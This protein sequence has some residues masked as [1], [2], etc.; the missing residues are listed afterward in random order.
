MDAN[1]VKTTPLYSAHLAL[2][3]KMISFA[4]YLLP[5]QYVGILEEHQA[6][7]ERAGVF[8]VSHMGEFIVR[9]PAAESYLQRLLT[10]DIGRLSVGRAQYSLMCNENGGVV[11]D[12][13]VYRKFTREYMLV[14]NANNIAKD[15]G[16]LQEHLQEEAEV[17]DI[18][19]DTALLAL[20]GPR[21][22]DILQ[23]LTNTDLSTLKYYHF[24][25]GQVGGLDCLISRTGYT[26]ED[27]F[28]L[29][30]AP[31]L[32]GEM[33]SRLLAAGK[34]YGLQPAGL[35]ARDTLR[36]E[37]SLPLYGNELTA[38]TTPL[39]AGLERF[40]DFGKP[41]FIGRE[42]LWRQKT[43][44]PKRRLQGLLML[45]QGVPRPGYPVLINNARAGEVTSGSY[46]PTLK[47]GIALAYLPV[48]LDPNAEIAVL[49]RNKPGRARLAQIPFHKRRKV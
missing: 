20:Q 28:E 13:I 37:A 18:S 40:V 5:V 39:E 10:T 27:G 2:G 4:G 7:R 31:S 15:L 29:F 34:P 43:Q 30:V 44:Q 22:A 35:G 49:L 36:L 33:W 38:S 41:V 3:A 6:V 9:G 47:A 17:L 32:A 16:W 48:N 25:S 45:D 19:E 12:V 11:D 1:K 14:V 8:D 24:T 21:A 23:P 42:A 26:G 46:S